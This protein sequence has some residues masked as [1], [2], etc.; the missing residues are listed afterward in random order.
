MAHKSIL[1]LALLLVLW[2]SLNAATYYVATSGS[3]SNPGTLALPW[4]SIQKA[5]NTLLPGDTALIREGI[6]NERVLL[7]NSGL[8][9]QYILFAAFPGETPTIDGSGI[10]WGNWNGLFDISGLSYIKVSGLKIVHA[11]YA[12]IWVE[13]SDHIILEN[14][15]TYDTYSSGIGIWY[16]NDILVQNNEVEKACSGG[17]QECI[18][19]AGSAYADIFGNHVHDNGPNA[20]NGGEG[21]DVKQGSHHIDIHQNHVHHINDRIGIY[22]DAWDMH[23]HHIN[24]YQNRVHHCSE[25]GMAV[26]S[27]NGGLIEEVKLF[28][29]LI[30]FN[31]YGGIEL[32]AWSDIGFTGPKPIKHIQITNNTCYQNGLYDNGWGYGIVVDNPQAEDIQ[33]R[34]NICSQNSAQIAIAQIQSGGIVSHNLCFGNNTAD[35]TLYGSDSILLNPLFTDEAAF[36]FHLQSNSPAIDAADNANAPDTDFD[37][38][39]RPAGNAT[40]IGAYEYQLPSSSRNTPSPNNLRITLYPNPATTQLTLSLEDASLTT[41]CTIQIFDA[42]ARRVFT[43]T[44]TPQDSHIQIHINNLPPGLYFIRITTHQKR[45]SLQKVSVR[46]Q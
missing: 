39:P 15:Y 5:A 34:N 45:T 14:N 23:T 35:G 41:P 40:D 6:Y 43:T 27:E 12:G 8:P 21:I 7:Q 10:S 1:A 36:D 26:A 44:K 17:E 16:S 22:A 25:S 9:D 38:N 46:P 20:D 4:A 11:T 19:I 42:K 28:N 30:Y 3:D 2:S 24:I 31:K 29:N 18:T 13:E 33:I 32:G 37:G